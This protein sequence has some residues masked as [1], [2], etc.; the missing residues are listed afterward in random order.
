[1]GPLVRFFRSYPLVAATIAVGVVGAVLELGG[2]PLLAR[3]VL[4]VFAV[5]VALRQ[6]R[7]MVADLR[8][9]TYG[10]DVLAVT[11][12]GATVAVGEHWAALVVCLM[13]AGGEA[14][15]DYAAG[16]AQRELSALLERA[17]VIAHLVVDGSVADVP[18]ARVHAGDELLVK[19]G[20][21]VPVDGVLT[22]AGA[23]LDE[24][25][26]T[27]ESLPVEHGRGDSLLSGSVNGREVVRMRATAAAA[28]SQYQRIIE[29]VRQ[30][31]GSKAPFVRLADRVAVP[32]TLVSLGVAATAWA[33]SGDPVRF[34]EVLVVATPCPLIIAAPVAFMAGMSRAALG[35][36]IVKNGGT[37]EQLSRV[38]TA[39]FDKTGTLTYGRPEVAAVLPGP[40]LEPD[41]LLG[42]A[43]AVEQYSTHPLAAAV[44]HAAREQGLPLRHGT[45]VEE[46]TAHGVRATVAGR[47]V[48]VGKEGFVAAE[49]VDP[50]TAAAAPEN[51]S[52]PG[53]APRPGSAARPGPA[54]R[55]GSAPES[56]LAPGHT[57]VHVGVD[58][59]HAGTI[60]LADRVRAE[61]PATL[62]ALHRAGVGTTVMLTGD[63]EATA[64]GIGAAIGI[65][66]VRAG[67]LP[68]HKVEAVRGL[69]DRPVM[70]VG[71]GVNDAPV[72]A[73]ADVGVAM[74]AR[75]STA[76]S[77]SAD[78]VIMLD[79]L[80][81]TVRA[82]Q[83]GRRTMRV[84]WQAIG[85]GV[86]LSVGLMV[87][88]AVGLLPAIVGAWTQEA[89]DLACILWALLA[90]RPGAAERAEEAFLAA[91]DHA[92]PGVREPA[93]TTP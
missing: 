55:P 85:L 1:M 20:E 71:D 42:L 31:Q 75:G 86:A 52:G 45:E 62:A 67:L 24:S 44:V 4:T 90:S 79:D 23:Y 73:V 50:P 34:A 21:I 38:R 49:V 51:G 18:V 87:V 22:S 57:A 82:V 80:A 76:A 65:D 88:A 37:L 59:R 16:R 92:A 70:M 28:D 39:A 77:E 25:S 47:R 2:Q 27:G 66:D 69:R 32:F 93:L 53:P 7:A 43:A 10:V 9:G 89:V 35:G 72:L 14:L 46:T 56:A 63:A 30:A 40:G 36:I 11:A 48:V 19:P 58:G 54:A 84:A 29:L 8:A 81:R 5:A 74:G 33:V 61:T 6:A 60:W 17:P 26:L 15:E 13:L 91:G 41:E 78:V 12:I 64:R 83:I 68:E 3:W